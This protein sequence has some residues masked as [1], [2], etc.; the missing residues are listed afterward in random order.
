MTRC[1]FLNSKSDGLYIC[2][3]PICHV[4]KISIRNHAFE[5][6]RKLQHM[7]FSRS[8]LNRNL[9]F[10]M[11]TIFQNLTCWKIFISKSNALYFFQFKIWRVV[12]TS[13]QNLTRCKNFN[14][15]SDKF[16]NFSPKPDFCFVFQVLNDCL[17]FLST[18]LPVY[19]E[20]YN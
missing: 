20:E 13:N 7:S 12:K 6:A 3:F 18:L 9:I 11:Q 5:K 8:K 2:Q 17:Y 1:F 15:K 4:K 14:S 19:F 10:W 16:Q